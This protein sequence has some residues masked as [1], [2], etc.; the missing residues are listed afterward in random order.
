MVYILDKSK[1][2]NTITRS[3]NCSDFF[4]CACRLDQSICA[5]RSTCTT[6]V[7]ILLEVGSA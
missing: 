5:C 3:R 7:L 4:D 6:Y 2:I 1:T